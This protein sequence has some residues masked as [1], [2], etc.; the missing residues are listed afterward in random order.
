M[1]PC[2]LDV[3]SWFLSR[4]RVSMRPLG[5]GSP[6]PLLARAPQN[7]FESIDLSDNTIARVENFPKLTKLKALHLNNNKVNH[8]A[9][10]L[11]GAPA[12]SQREGNIRVVAD[13]T[14]RGG[15]ARCR[16]ARCRAGWCRTARCARQV[17]TLERSRWSIRAR[18][19]P[20]CM[21]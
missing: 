14:P 21:R 1:G 7:Q 5:D 6:T 9:P 10:N 20:P 3:A 2:S 18:G 4:T 8:I 11:Q 16:A 19:S 13:A 15:G 12:G 17:T